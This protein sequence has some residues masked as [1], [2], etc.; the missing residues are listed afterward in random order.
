MGD[1]NVKS[2]PKNF[3]GI[4]NKITFHSN[5]PLEREYL[6]KLSQENNFR[7]KNVKYIPGINVGN[8]ADSL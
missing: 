5:F 1:R 7:I 3:I 4:S 8:D 6:D 2:V